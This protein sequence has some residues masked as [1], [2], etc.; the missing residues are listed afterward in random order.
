MTG[1]T[2]TVI[3][4]CSTT[5]SITAVATLF[6]IFQSIAKKKQGNNNNS[7]NAE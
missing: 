6:K 5:K 7:T 2:S 4:Y 1:T 3:Y